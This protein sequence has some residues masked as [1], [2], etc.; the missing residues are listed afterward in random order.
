MDEQISKELTR[1]RI[2]IQLQI[3]CNS[4]EDLRIQGIVAQSI[5]DGE[6]R[7]KLI[8]NEMARTISCS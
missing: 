5:G 8:R 7:L 2:K 6:E 4:K 1:E 3:W